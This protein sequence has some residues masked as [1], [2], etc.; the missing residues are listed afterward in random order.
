MGSA[1][2]FDFPHA[3]KMTRADP[4]GMAIFSNRSINVSTFKYEKIPNVVVSINN[5]LGGIDIISSYIPSVYPNPKLNREEHIEQL[6]NAVNN[7][8]NPVIALGDY[9]EVYWD[10]EIKSFTNKTNLNNSRRSTALSYFKP[11]DH[12]FF[13]GKLECVQFDE[14]YD[15]DQNH[16]GIVGTYQMKSGI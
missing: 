6:V 5:E 15:E 16:L 9:N 2:K 1:L 4:F 11:Y 8:Q 7:T 14:I 13:S 12:I 10:Q 3:Y